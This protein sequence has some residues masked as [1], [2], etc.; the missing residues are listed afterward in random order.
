M[1]SFGIRHNSASKTGLVVTV[2]WT[3]EKRPNG[4]RTPSKSFE[5]LKR[6]VP[7]TADGVA[8]DGDKQEFIEEI[9][10]T[11]SKRTQRPEAA[12]YQDYNPVPGG[13]QIQNASNSNYCTLTAPAYNFDRNEDVLITA[14]HCV[15]WSKG[16]TIYQPLS[17]YQKLGESTDFASTN[18]KLDVGEL[19]RFGHDAK[20]RLASKSSGYDYYILG[21]LSI[22]H[23]KDMAYYGQYLT[24]QGRTSGRVG[25]RVL[26]VT[27]DERW[28][29]M[30]YETS[31]GDSGGPWF[32]IQNTDEAY[33]AGVHNGTIDHD[34]DGSYDE[35]YASTAVKAEEALNIQ[36]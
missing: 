1:V 20:Y 16:T 24:L 19:K 12:Y 31:G 22:N 8:E 2:N 10:V 27:S 34:G 23:L 30:D 17:T 14:G 18:N 4:E 15:S 9:P 21:I 7:K 33:I 6:D 13:C 5:E 35:A 26:E 11:V 25:A 32:D 28:V 36:F 29:I 3:K